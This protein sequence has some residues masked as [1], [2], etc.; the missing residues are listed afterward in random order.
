MGW[1]AFLFPLLIN[2]LYHIVYE[3]SAQQATPGKRAMGL[4]VCGALGQRLLPQR[5]MFRH[6]LKFFSFIL[7]CVPLVHLLFSKRGQLLHDACVGSFILPKEYPQVVAPEEG[8]LRPHKAQV[9]T[10]KHRIVASLFDSAVFCAIFQLIL[11]PMVL[12]ASRM[13]VGI[14]FGNSIFAT[15]FLYVLL[16]FIASIAAVLL[17]AATEASALQATPGKIIAGLRVTGPNGRRITFSQALGKQF[18]QG[19]VY[20]SLYPII[21]FAWA[22]SAVFAAAESPVAIIAVCTY[23]FAYGMILC[24]TFKTGQTLLDRICERYVLLDTSALSYAFETPSDTARLTEKWRL[25][26]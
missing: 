10:V 1:P 24:F 9:A 23:F 11:A 17:F 13:L 6:G 21:F 5:L 16:P 4:S 2:H 18:N 12:L 15:A 3:S 7:I 8:L 25:E 20:L 14:D 19:L 26:S 22:I